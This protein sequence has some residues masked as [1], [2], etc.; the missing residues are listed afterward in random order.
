MTF[1]R[2]D[3]QQAYEKIKEQIITLELAPG[4]QLSAQ[5]LAESLDMGLTPVEEALKLLAHDELVVITPRHGIYVAAVSVADLEQLSEMRVPLEALCARLAAQRATPDDLVVLEALRQE[6][7][8]VSSGDSQRLFQ[9][10]HK[11]H[12]AI[13][14]A[15]HNK[16]LSRTL[17][18]YFGL[19]QRL[20]Y[21]ALPRLGFLPTAV[22]DH[23]ALVD[24][25]ET[26]DADAAERIMRS[27]VQNF[28]DKVRDILIEEMD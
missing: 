8:S 13:A 12:Q 20:W 18:H 17:D 14:R 24:V 19:S 21:L 22:A 15:A 16:Y 5:T 7:A 25:I 1:I 6:Q 3:T 28:Y 9:I 11:F 27:H 23:L 2:I 4:V 26:G 10:D